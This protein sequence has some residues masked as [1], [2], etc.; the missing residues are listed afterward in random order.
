MTD[1][2]R[3]VS[4]YTNQS[5]SAIHHTLQASR[6]RIIIG[7]VSHRAISSTAL[8]SKQDT[9]KRAAW[10]VEAA[11]S[12]R[13]LSKE[14]VSIEE[15]TSLEHATGDPY[16]NVYTALIQTHLPKL[17]DIGVIE[18]DDD[19]KIVY[20]DHNLIALAIVASITSPVAQLLFHD[21]VADL[22]RRDESALR[23]STGD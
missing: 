23:D 2:H 7:L 18:Y 21:A 15:E 16:H 22:Y 11:V 4:E 20:P 17:A 19:R 10:S 1:P 8:D 9:S 14:I 3:I 13:Q 12:V 5:L 6:R